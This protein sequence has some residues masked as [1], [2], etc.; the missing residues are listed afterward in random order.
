M[1]TIAKAVVAGFLLTTVSMNHFVA[2]DPTTKTLQNVKAADQTM[3]PVADK[4][5]DAKAEKTLTEEQKQ[6]M[7]QQ[8]M[9]QMMHRE[10]RNELA[11]Q[12]M[13]TT[14]PSML[15]K[16]FLFTP[17]ILNAA[18][19]PTLSN[20]GFVSRLIAEAG[21]YFVFPH[22]VNLSN[23]IMQ[24]FA[25]T[26]ISLMS[27]TSFPILRSCCFQTWQSA[28]THLMF[29]EKG[30]QIM[31]SFVQ[32]GIQKIHQTLTSKILRLVDLSSHI[33]QS[34]PLAKQIVANIHGTDVTKLDSE[35]YKD[36][37]KNWTNIAQDA[38][39]SGEQMRAS[40]MLNIILG[41]TTIALI[42]AGLSHAVSTMFK[43]S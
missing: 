1:K 15:G 20:E 22:L 16:V 42:G 39:N 14:Q 36:E 13:Y 38:I 12:S 7:M 31:P 27:L 6:Q 17:A 2:A 34:G 3:Q 9:Q 33:G 28:L 43:A 37:I 5:Q 18:L 29:S 25:M 19:N 8:W 23:P 24:S 11:T 32:A 40:V 35:K 4:N 10:I 26:G 30:L 21:A 41:K